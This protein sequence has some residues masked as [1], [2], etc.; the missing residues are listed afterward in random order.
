MEVGVMREHIHF[1]PL[2]VNFEEL[3]TW[4]IA[5]VHRVDRKV[6]PRTVIVKEVRRTASPVLIERENRK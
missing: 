1:A 5:R 2:A 3:H 4:Q 6:I